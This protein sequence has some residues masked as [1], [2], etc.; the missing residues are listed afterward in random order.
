[1][2]LPQLYQQSR[3]L[4]FFLSS[5]YA[6]KQWCGLEWRVGRELLKQQE[7]ERL[8]FL[9]LDQADIPGLYSIDG[10]LDINGM[11]DEEAAGQILK[12]LARLEPPPPPG[13]QNLFELLNA[14]QKK[15]TKFALQAVRTGRIPD[16]VVR[17]ALTA[18]QTLLTEIRSASNAVDNAL[19]PQISEH[20][21]RVLERPRTNERTKLTEALPV[22]PLILG[23]KTNFT[24]AKD[25]D[26]IW[27]NLTRPPWR[28]WIWVAAGIL[29]FAICYF[30]AVQLIV[31]S[32]QRL[33]PIDDVLDTGVH[34]KLDAKFWATSDCQQWQLSENLL[35]IKGPGLAMLKVGQGK[36]LYDFT[37]RFFVQ[38]EKGKKASWFL[39]GQDAEVGIHPEKLRA[40]GFDLRLDDPEGPSPLSV[41]AYTLPGHTR[42][43]KL[44]LLIN[45]FVQTE[46]IFK[47]EMHVVASKVLL[48]VTQ[49]PLHQYRDKRIAVETIGVPWEKP[50][51][52]SRF[53]HG[54]IG[55]FGTWE[56]NNDVIVKD[57]S[58]T[59]IR[60]WF[61]Y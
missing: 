12:R 30:V 50:F 58:I 11:P 44:P 14:R 51:E 35:H 52:D 39:R 53:D 17:T 41:E 8:M 10:Y 1:V 48:T 4:V 25:L 13:I 43:G 57:L 23:E 61:L 42:I 28:K 7:D 19:L 21:S 9:R 40:L 18:L 26:R 37:L 27:K 3:L 32:R 5:F 47:V 56:A 2:Y 22:I 29:G 49:N 20:L 6:S 31:G 55:L 45:N 24:I 36:S 15:K 46:D 33:K 60:K 38:I 34:G 59:P 54:S 16:K